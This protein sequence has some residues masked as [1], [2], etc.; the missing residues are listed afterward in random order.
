MRCTASCLGTFT[1]TAALAL[2]GC[3][4]EKPVDLAPTAA[5][6]EAAKPKSAQAVSVEIVKD[7]SQVSFVMDAPLEK[8]R[9]KVNGATTGTIQVDPTDLT[10][11]TGLIRIDI[12]GIE[13]FQAVADENGQFGAEKKSDLQNQHAR[14]WLEISD[15][16]PPADRQENRVVQF[17]ID[18]VRDASARDLTKLTG[19]ERKV[20]ATVAGSFRLHRRKVEKSARVEITFKYAGDRLESA[21]FRTLEP[22]VVALE[23]HDVRPR[24]AFGK[25]AQ[26]T[27][28]ALA[29]KVAKEARVSFELQA[30]TK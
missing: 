9:G 23:A 2:F 1:L 14:A 27:L 17:K 25:L 4:K 16:A 29:P 6:L 11:S 5:A 15:D 19:R 7:T 21:T 18:A 10:R 28:A 12:G 8:I 22:V 30:Q 24:E 20:T 26:K 13:L 3:S